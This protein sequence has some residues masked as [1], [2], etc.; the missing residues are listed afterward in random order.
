MSELNLA[1]QLVRESS[2][3]MIKSLPLKARLCQSE[4]NNCHSEQREESHLQH[5]HSERPTGVVRI[6][7]AS[8]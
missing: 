3:S 6:S 5:C 7:K 2:V 1:K 8:P 4:R